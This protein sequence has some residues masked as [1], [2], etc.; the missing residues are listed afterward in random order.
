MRYLVAVFIGNYVPKGAVISTQCLYSGIY[1]QFPEEC[2]KLGFTN[3]APIEA[4]WK[5][6][7]RWGLRDAR[8]QKLIRHVGLPKSGEWQRI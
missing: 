5:N 6:Q 3:S 8:D 7:I 4:K 1:S 2:R